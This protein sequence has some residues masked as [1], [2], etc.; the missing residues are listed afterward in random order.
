MGDFEVD[1]VTR[2]R[3][4]LHEACL[5]EDFPYLSVTANDQML[6]I[7]LRREIQVGGISVVLIIDPFVD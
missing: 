1:L 3:R 7:K 4:K 6:Q 2:L 5:E